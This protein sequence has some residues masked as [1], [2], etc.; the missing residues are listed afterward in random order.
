ASE[1]QNGQSD[2]GSQV[3]TKKPASGLSGGAIKPEISTGLPLSAMSLSDISRPRT[4]EALYISS[5]RILSPARAARRYDHAI[6][7]PAIAR[8]LLRRI[9]GGPTRPGRAPVR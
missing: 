6:P 3:S 8:R 5:N 2:T 9:G 7:T 4:P 1:L